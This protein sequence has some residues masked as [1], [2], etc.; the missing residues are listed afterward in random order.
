MANAGKKQEWFSGAEAECFKGLFQE[1]SFEEYLEIVVREPQVTRTSFQRIYD[2]LTGY[3]AHTY[4][5]FNRKEIVHYNFFDDPFTNG[6]NRLFGLDMPLMELVNIFKSAA[7]KFSHDKRI[8]LL[9][10]PVGS[11]KSTIV[12]LLKKGLEAYSKTDEGKLFSVMWQV[13]PDDEEG[14]YILGRIKQES[15]RVV[16]PMLEEPL[17]L[18]P[19][20]HGIRS[21]IIQKINAQIKE[22]GIHYRVEPTGDAC[23]VCRSYFTKF[24]ER[25]DGNWQKVFREHLR[26]HRFYLFEKDRRGIGTFQPKD[27]KNQDSTE[28]TGDVN[29][30]KIA[31]Y[32][33]DSDP[34]AFNFDGEFNIANRGIVEFIEILKL[35]VAFLYD[36]LCATQEHKIK[37]KKFPQIDIDEVIIGHTN[38]AEFKK[39]QKNEMM[40]A[41]RDR[42]LKV[43]IPYVLEMSK[44]QKIYERDYGS[45]QLEAKK[46]HFAPH[47]LEM[48]ALWVILT[49][50]QEPKEIKM[51]VVS[52]AKLYDGKAHDYKDEDIVN[53][54][55]SEPGAEREGMEGIS[56]RYI[57]DKL[58]NCLV[59]NTECINPF[60]LIGPD[61]ELA[62][63]LENH[64]SITADKTKI[65]RYQELLIRTCEEYEDKVKDDVKNAIIGDKEAVKALFSNYLDNIMAYTEGRTITDQFTGQARPPNEEL[66]RSI[67]EKLDPPVSSSQKD[68]YRR[69]VMSKVGV[70]AREGKIFDYD[71]NERLRKAL[72]RKL[73]ED[74]KDSLKLASI[75]STVVPQ[76]TI[77]KVELAKKYLIEKFGYCPVCATD[78]LNYVASIF[79]RGEQKS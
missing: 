56:P 43:N 15:P 39:L 42:T 64:A 2:M 79:A 58:A 69:E 36:L 73:F 72:E 11:A 74:R 10:G 78:A 60:M 18:L 57:Q 65:E 21:S 13:A 53:K 40:E 68:D 75:V 29:Y 62:S 66:M 46:K 26:V 38:E 22:R 4:K 28:L 44:E 25:Y 49:R 63:G 1:M 30:R 61:G 5:L 3:G 70:M 76:E 32:G 48:V 19:E 27:E 52:K 41:M 34:R 23:P 51:S 20:D 8:I 31:E 77:D 7:A 71:S 50:I 35:D 14:K 55:K 33:S 45:E 6:K 12:S 24:L 54:L 47:T 16:C 37:P 59:Q 9:M 67:E 17:N